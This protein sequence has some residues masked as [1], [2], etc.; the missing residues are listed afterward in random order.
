MVIN[1]IRVR[2]F[3]EEKGNRTS[4][5]PQCRADDQNIEVIA[6]LLNGIRLIAVN[7]RNSHLATWR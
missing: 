2:I 3:Q 7:H 6:C 5:D 4:K 1:L